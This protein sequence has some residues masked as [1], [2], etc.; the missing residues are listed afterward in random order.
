MADYPDIE[1]KL[2]LKMSERLRHVGEQVLGGQIGNVDE[3]LKMFGLKLDTE[4]RLVDCALRAAQAMFDQTKLR[5]DEVIS[6]AERSRDRLQKMATLVTAL[7]GIVITI[8]GAFGF[9]Q[10]WDVSQMATEIRKVKDDAVTGQTESSKALD[11]IKKARGEIQTAQKE[12]APLALSLGDLKGSLIE[13]VR[14]RLFN[15]VLDGKLADARRDYRTLRD[16]AGLEEALT[17]VDFLQLVVFVPKP[18]KDEMV[19]E[20]M[21]E[22]GADSL[23][24]ADASIVVRASVLRIAYSILTGQSKPGRQPLYN[25]LR[26]YLK[27]NPNAALRAVMIPEGLLATVHEDLA[28]EL[29]ALGQLTTAKL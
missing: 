21:A 16:L 11:E 19:A 7:A 5:A 29:R 4:Q 24:L 8:L 2:L 17:V 3:K 28:A 13:I 22:I 20:L 6:S 18:S 27:N 25:Q 23:K 15:A 14:T 12:V 1:F 26:D 10:I 9:K